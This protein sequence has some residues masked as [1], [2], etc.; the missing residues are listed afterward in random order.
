VS[1]VT[2]KDI[3]NELGISIATVSRVLNGSGY[4]SEEV[5]KKVLETAKKF[6]YHP[7]AI[8]RS[9]KSERTNTIGVI[10]PDISNPYFMK[11]SKGIEDTLYEHGYNLIF[12]SGDEKPEKEKRF[13]KVLLEKRVDAIVLASS[14]NNEKAIEEVYQ[15]GVP[16]VLVDRKINNLSMNLESVVE[17][18]TYGAYHLT[19]Y[20]INHGHTRLGIING[21]LKVSSGMERFEG[22]QMAMKEMGLIHDEQ[23]VFNGNFTKESGM[24]AVDYFLSLQK[25]PTA[26]LSF[27]NTMGLGAIIQLIRK[28]IKIPEE[29]VV[30]SYGEIEAVELLK[31]NSIICNVQFPYE[32]GCRVGEIL[33]HRLMHK[34]IPSQDHVFKPMFNVPV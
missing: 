17:D 12:M 10:I 6:Q 33:L 34:A 3:A 1:K 32:M 25:R 24:A 2:I 27:N 4:A 15:S 13:L 5:R 30:A 8:A 11:I 29:M 26:I 14:G 19:K 18:N 7:N 20:L 21:L 9:L 22:F 23:L 31:P 16:I 28:G